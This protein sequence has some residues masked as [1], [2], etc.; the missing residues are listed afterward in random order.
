MNETDTLDLTVVVCTKNVENM[1]VDAL[2][3][4]V[5]NQ[6]KDILFIDG[7]STDRT[8]EL[9]KPF[10]TRMLKDPGRGLAIAR[11]LGVDNA[12][13]KYVS[14]VG[15]DNIMPKGSLRRMIEYMEEHKCSGVSTRTVLRDKGSYI[16]WAQ[17]IYK[18]KYTPGFKSVVGTPILFET[19]VIRKYKYNPF[20][21]N[22]DDTDLCERMARDGHRFAIADVDCIEVGFTSL[23][24]VLERWQRYGR[25]DC[26]FYTTYSGDW[27]FARKLKSWFHPFETEV[28][29][30]F[31]QVKLWEFAAILPFLLFITGIRYF[32]WVRTAH[33]LKK[34][35]H[36]IPGVAAK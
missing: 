26:L 7:N 36:P 6:P 31:K 5:E 8:V 27:T 14:F 2:K 24:F 30:T 34:K 1:V 35:L 12:T 25:G 15:P 16:G 13:T 3:S 33:R 10:I 20:F 4:V 32:S 22:S 19:E 23:D 21:T 17:D 18:R 9:S 28:I 29:A 11:N